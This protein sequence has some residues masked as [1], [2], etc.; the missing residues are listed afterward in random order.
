MITKKAFMNFA[1]F[2]RKDVVAELDPEKRN[3][4]SQMDDEKARRMIAEMM[5]EQF[6]SRILNFFEKFFSFHGMKETF[7]ILMLYKFLS[8]I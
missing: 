3:N 8:H 7:L 4:L 5:R 6:K 2:K 1:N